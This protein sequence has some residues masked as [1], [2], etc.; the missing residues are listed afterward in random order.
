M[1]D[2]DWSVTFQRPLR[3]SGVV[4]AHLEGLIHAGR[5]GPGD[6]LPPER[7][8]AERLGVSR[9]SVRDG[10]Q[11][12]A[13]KGLAERSPGRGTIVTASPIEAQQQLLDNLSTHERRVAEIIDL[14]QACEP[15]V[16][17][18]A[19]QRAT[20]VDL[21]RIES[22]LNEASVDSTPER[23][24]ELDERFHAEVARAS[25]NPLLLSLIQVAPEWMRPTRAVTH[26]TVEARELSIQGHREILEA[27]RARD[28]T[29]AT[30]AMVAHVN[31]VSKIQ[32]QRKTPQPSH[33][34][35]ESMP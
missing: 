19:A 15:A 14:R 12:L 7:E 28:A 26:A 23:A 1:P 10:M 34:P 22:V 13:L 16:A 9:A 31:D 33:P 4:A 32:N 3:A 11:E 21:A 20:A 18:R 30:A 17:A 24:V 6:K 2:E 8:L 29:A 25:R 35:K 5:F 27:I